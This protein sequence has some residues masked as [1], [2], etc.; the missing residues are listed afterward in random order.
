MKPKIQALLYLFPALLGVSVQAQTTIATDS[1]GNYSSWGSPAGSA[2]VAN[3]GTGFGTW[4]FANTAGGNGSENGS[5][6]GGSAQLG[7]GANINS[8][9]GN[10]WGLY[11]NS[12]QTAEAYMPFSEGN[13]TAGQTFS[14]QMQNNDINTGGTV[15]F[16]LWNNLNQSVFEFYF[17]GGGSAYNINVWQNSSTGNQIAT[18]VGYTSSP[19]TLDF[20]LGVDN[21]WQFSIYEGDTLEQTL[22]SGTDGDLWDNVSQVRLFNYNSGSGSSDNVGFNNADITSTPEPSTLALGSLSGLAFLFVIRRRH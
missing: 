3:G 17:T 16:S 14:L 12:G 6:L 1:A 10:S 2:T 4:T 7:Q 18:S 22:N 21:A 19:L 8:L 9:S 11:A 13:L 15:G 20:T 5:F